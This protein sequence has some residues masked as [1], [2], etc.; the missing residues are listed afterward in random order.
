[1]ARSQ[2]LWNHLRWDLLALIILGLLV[3]AY[4]TVQSPRFQPSDSPMT[5]GSK[6]PD[7]TE[8]DLLLVLP[9]A[10]AAQATNFDNLDCSFAW[11]NAL[12]HHFG[13]FA[14][15]PAN[16]VTPQLLA[17]HSVAIVPSRVASE[18]SSVVREDLETFVRQGGVL[19]VETPRQGWDRITGMSTVG[20]VD[21]A[22]LITSVDGVHREMIDATDEEPHHPLFDVPLSGRILPASGLD[23]D[24]G[25]STEVAFEVDERP[26]LV[27]RP[28]EEGYVY[29]LLF[30]FACSLTA[31]YQGKPTQELSFGPPDREP[32]LPTSHRVAD[33]RLLATDVPYAEVLQRALFERLT[34]ARPVARLWP[35]PGDARGAAMSHHPANSSPRAAFAYADRA[36]KQEARST[37]FATADNWSSHHHSL[38]NEIGADVGMIWVLGQKRNPITEGV[39]PGAFEPIARE[40][41]LPDQRALFEMAGG[42]RSTTLVRTE[43]TLWQTDWATTFR[44]LAGAGLRVD[45]SF[46]PSEPSQFG[47]LFGTAM[48]FYPL[49]ELG[50]PLPLLEAPFVLDGSGLTRA[51]LRQLFESS[52]AGFHQPLALNL[53]AEAMVEAPSA[54]M[55][56]GYRQ[57]HEMAAE[58]DH[59]L[60]TVQDYVDFLAARRR[61]VLTSQWSPTDG[62]LT[63]SVNLLGIRLPGSE[64]GAVPSVAVP[65]EFRGGAVARV[66]IDDERLLP[67]ALSTS[68]D[69]RELLIELP[70]GRHVISVFYHSP[71]E[72]ESES[73][74]E[75]DEGS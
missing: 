17:G 13:T 52:A 26:G 5:Q 23:A 57:F 24:G 41:T 53:S 68:G 45:T 2:L 75:S 11:V 31:M 8:G 3:F 46:G 61:A 27:I 30:D 14:S 40:V 59:W 7:R 72:P 10:P 15:A 4:S 37:L 56:L 18:L 58:Y 25:S 70:A 60:T 74:G 36:R 22:T 35:F 20:E 47:Y 49:D 54:E 55:L 43:E 73:E 42:G 12:G 69:G 64:D 63:V 19:I 51:R 39:G 28:L 29:S 44:T 66:K 34:T 33:E 62:R 65:A 6:P 67:N 71:P 1:M 9:D 50:L 16:S 21:Q 38:A 32:W 48:P